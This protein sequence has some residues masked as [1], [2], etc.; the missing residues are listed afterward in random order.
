M[1]AKSGFRNDLVF[2]WTE[3]GIDTDKMVLD[4]TLGEPD[5]S[6]GLKDEEDDFLTNKRDLDGK[7]NY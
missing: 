4:T 5:L 6:D 2:D 7:S 3:R 1:A